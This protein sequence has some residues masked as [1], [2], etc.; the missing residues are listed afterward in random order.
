[1]SAIMTLAPSPAR[2]SEYVRPMPLAA[3][4][5][6][7]T[8]PSSVIR[9]PFGSAWVRPVAQPHPLHQRSASRGP[10]RDVR[11]L[12]RAVLEPCQRLVVDVQRGLGRGIVEGR[13]DRNGDPAFLDPQVITFPGLELPAATARANG[14]QND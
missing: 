6:M 12:D 10:P 13:V 11:R 4:V 5:T 2:A 7:T 3:P 8:R 14:L 9:P 1:M